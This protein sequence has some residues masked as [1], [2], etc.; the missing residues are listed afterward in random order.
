MQIQQIRNATLRITYAG[1]LFL[2]DPYLTAKHQMPS[3]TGK[4]PNPLV[5]LPYPAQEIIS[6]IEMVCVSHL[7]SDHFDT[8]AQNLLPRDIPVLCQSGDES[9]I[10]D[11]G[12]CNVIPVADAVSWQGIRIIR[13]KGQH[14]T[15]DVLKEMGNASGFVFQAEGEPT[16]YW[17]GD[18]IWCK[19]VADAIDKTQPD[20]IITHS[21]GAVWGDNVL[22]LMDAAQTV[23]VCRAA[24]KAFVVATHME[25]LDHATVSRSDL[26]AFAK[27]KGIKPDQLLIPADGELLNF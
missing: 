12:F 21:C 13:T 9:E 4:S 16:V 26:R 10:E 3:Y 24:P 1:K 19:A 5:E 22:I 15:G 8:T 27:I 20:I 11:R 18:T 14:G 2:T 23:D 6:G 25:A 17:T 7:H